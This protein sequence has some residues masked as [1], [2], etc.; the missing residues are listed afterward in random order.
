MSSR[1]PGATKNRV[2]LNAFKLGVVL[3][4]VIALAIGLARKSGS[5][6]NV[7]NFLWALVVAIVEL[8]P[9]PGWGGLQLS[10]SFPVLLAGRGRTG[11]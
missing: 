11:P 5:T 7:T 10:L 4:V 1:L 6:L 2:A 9:V 3:P 8:V